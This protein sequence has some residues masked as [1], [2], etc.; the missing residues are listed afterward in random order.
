MQQDINVFQLPC[1]GW[2]RKSVKTLH[3]F[4]FRISVIEIPYREY[5][6]Q[7]QVLQRQFHDKFLTNI[8]FSFSQSIKLDMNAV[9]LIVS[10]KLLS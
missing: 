1:V 5:W 4:I 8:F 10:V 9:C 3:K 6:R 7:K 2:T